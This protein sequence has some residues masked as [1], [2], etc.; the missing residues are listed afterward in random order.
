MS[1]P[2]LPLAEVVQ[3]IRAFDSAPAHDQLDTIRTLV[4]GHQVTC[5]KWGQGWRYRRARVLKPGQMVHHVGDLI[6]RE[7][8]PA[9]IGRANATGFGV[10]YLGDRRDTALSEVRAKDDDVVMSEFVIRPDRTMMIAPLGEAIQVQRTGRGFLAGD[11]SDTISKAMNAMEPSG[12]RAMLITD[13]FL[14]D[15]LTKADDD[16]SLS[17]AVAMAIYEKLPSVSAIAFPSR[18]Q[19]GALNFAVRVEGFWETWG[20]FAVQ[21]AH[22]RHLAQGFYDITEVRDVTGIWSDG[23]LEWSDAVDPTPNGVLQL[24]PPWFEHGS[25]KG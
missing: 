1:E 22:A 12:A 3:R 10:L 20:V 7:G 21:R 6:W 18:R 19:Y 14:L 5:L 13:A 8:V 9:R 17:S 11:A 25:A 16:Y 24:D 4:K 23:K 15:V 2:S